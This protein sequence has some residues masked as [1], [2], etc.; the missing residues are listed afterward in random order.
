MRLFTA[1]IPGQVNDKTYDNRNNGENKIISQFIRTGLNVLTLHDGNQVTQ[2]A[3]PWQ[4]P[5]A[6]GW[7]AWEQADLLG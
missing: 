2:P 1:G 6:A 3:S 4:C 7:P 5:E